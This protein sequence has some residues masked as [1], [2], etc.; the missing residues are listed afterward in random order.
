VDDQ[1]KIFTL[2]IEI[3]EK[4]GTV[5]SDISKIETDLKEHMRRTAVAEDR[6]EATERQLGKKI[7][8]LQKAHYMV[9]GALAFIGLIGVIA[10]I[11]NHL[12]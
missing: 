10:A 9:Q 2:L 8:S 4:I 5:R 3:H 1:A 12:I 6:I 11:Y 7:A